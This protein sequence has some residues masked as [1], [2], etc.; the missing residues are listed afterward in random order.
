MRTALATEV[1]AR[2]RRY[3]SHVQEV[4]RRTPNKAASWR[5]A[6]RLV[7]DLHEDLADAR[8]DVF[9]RYCRKTGPELV[10]KVARRLGCS[11]HRRL[12]QLSDRQRALLVEILERG[13]L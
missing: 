6:A 5:V 13:A 3:R 12:G 10:R 8:L 11:E 2:R 7:D 9:L 1:S 4:L